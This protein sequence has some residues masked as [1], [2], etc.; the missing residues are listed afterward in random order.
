MQFQIQTLLRKFSILH[1]RSI[2]GFIK[3]SYFIFVAI[4]WLIYV[5][6]PQALAA[7]N[8]IKEYGI[9]IL[10]EEK[11]TKAAENLNADITKLLPH[12]RNVQNYWHVTLYHGAYEIK[13]LSQIYSKIKELPLKPFTLTFTKISSTSD[14]WI[15]LGTEKTEYLQ[16]LHVSVVHL[17]SP[18]HKRPLARSADG[19][20]DMTSDRRQQIDAYGVSGVLELYNPHMTLFYQYP[21]NSELQEVAKKIE[22]HFKKNMIC[23]ASKIVLGELGYNGN[24]EKIVYNVDIPN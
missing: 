13:D 12:L 16:N 19:Y 18:Y 15:D 6:A 9:V 7:E 8:S 24:I 17:A 1:N 23:K 3:K 20:K 5:S 11:C 21:P 4:V 10:P 2:N 14:R 22:T